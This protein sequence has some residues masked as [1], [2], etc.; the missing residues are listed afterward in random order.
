MIVSVVSKTLTVVLLESLTPSLDVMKEPDQLVSTANANT[1]TVFLLDGFA[2]LNTTTTTTDATATAVSL[3]LIAQR[4]MTKLLSSTTAQV[5]VLLALLK[6]CA[7]T[8]FPQDGLARLNSMPTMMAVIASVEFPIPIVRTQPSSRRSLSLDV[9]RVRLATQGENVSKLVSA[10][11]SMEQLKTESHLLLPQ[12]RLP[13]LLC[14]R[15]HAK[16]TAAWRQSSLLS[17]QHASLPLIP[18]V[19]SS[20]TALSK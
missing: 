14:Q 13:R 6:V 3:I 1:K 9:L 10:R 8:L 20:S 11:L 18:L 2:R 19:V 12:E 15:A 5:K 4:E 17:R 7:R 16:E